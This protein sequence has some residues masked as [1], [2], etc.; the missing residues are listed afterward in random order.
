M[1]ITFIKYS[2][3][4]IQKQGQNIKIQHG[5]I[6]F[7]FCQLNSPTACLGAT[8]HSS[9]AGLIQAHRQLVDAQR[10]LCSILKAEAFGGRR[11][12]SLG[13]KTEEKEDDTFSF[14][15]LS[16]FFQHAH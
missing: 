14:C 3:V 11:S 16:L 13:K 6:C 2:Q 15:Y 9:D 10:R 7:H 12:P 8:Y 4:K 5:F 1:F